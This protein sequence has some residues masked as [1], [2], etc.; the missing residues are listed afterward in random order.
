MHVKYRSRVRTGHRL[1]S[2]NLDTTKVL[3]GPDL[4][5]LVSPGILNVVPSWDNCR[6]L[7]SNAARSEALG[8]LDKA[9]RVTS[10]NERL[11]R[12]ISLLLP[13]FSLMCCSTV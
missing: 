6:N 2:V 3:G 4:L 7:M 5:V 13:M 8:A 9:N 1:S 10:F 11:L 12:D